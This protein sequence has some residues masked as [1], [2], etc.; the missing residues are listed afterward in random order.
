MESCWFP[1]KG[2]RHAS[3]FADLNNEGVLD[4]F[5]HNHFQM[6]PETDGDVGVSAVNDAKEMTYSSVGEQP[7]VATGVP[8]TDWTELPIESLGTASSDLTAAAC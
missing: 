5:Y 2:R 1:E 3:F 4:F 6:L 8:D 7:I